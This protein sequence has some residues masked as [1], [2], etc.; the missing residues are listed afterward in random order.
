MRPSVH[1]FQ[2]PIGWTHALLSLTLATNAAW[3][4]ARRCAV[5][6]RRGEVMYVMREVSC[7][8]VVY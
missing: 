2:R 1:I 6:P 3:C 4:F 8:P 5:L 7:S